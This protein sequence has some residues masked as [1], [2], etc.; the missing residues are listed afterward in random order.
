MSEATRVF[1]HRG[2]LA[3]ALSHGMVARLAECDAMYDLDSQQLTRPPPRRAATWAADGAATREAA[4]EAAEAEA[5]R[6]TSA[7]LDS[8][9]VT[10]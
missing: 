9:Q 10:L 6:R 5:A 4:C 8:P 7:A 1:A 2:Y 3:G